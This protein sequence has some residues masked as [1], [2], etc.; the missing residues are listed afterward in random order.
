LEKDKTG[1]LPDESKY[2]LYDESVE[3]LAARG[4][5]QDSFV[6]F[7]TLAH[8]G[9]L[10]EAADFGG[11]PL[12]GLGAGARSYSDA[13]HYSTDFAVGRTATLDIIRGFVEHDHRQSE[14]LG[15]GFVL[16]EDERRRRFCILNLSLGRLDPAAYAQRFGARSLSDFDEELEAL[17]K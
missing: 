16:D 12:L 11:V 17:A 2:A 7:T 9:L 6:R 4:Y 10:Q 13:V 8:D 14:R 3:H 1:F 15:L 5:R